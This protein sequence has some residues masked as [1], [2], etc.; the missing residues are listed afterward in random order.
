MT[1]HIRMNHRENYGRTGISRVSNPTGAVEDRFI[2][3]TGAGIMSDTRDSRSEH[4]WNTMCLYSR[5]GTYSVDSLRD[6][7]NATGGSR[8]NI[9]M[10][11]FAKMRK[12]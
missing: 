1:K 8:R 7:R 2:L 9:K 11:N 12:E 10:I 6:V 3:P 5:M 4:A